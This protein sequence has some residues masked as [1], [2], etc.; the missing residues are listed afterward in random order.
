MS[1]DKQPRPP[2]GDSPEKNDESVRLHRRGFFTQGF[3]ELLRPLADMV[4]ERLARVGIPLEE[5]ACEERGPGGY[6]YGGASAAPAAEPRAAAPARRTVLR[7]PGALR[8]SEFLDRCLGSGQCVNACPVSAIRM[9]HGGDPYL[10]HKPYIEPREQACILCRD[11][12]CMQTCPSGALVPVARE[13]IRMG[14]AVVREDICLR[15]QGEDCRICAD[16]CPLGVRAIDISYEYGPVL[17]FDSGCV[18]CGV[19]EMHCPVE[20]RAIR[21]EPVDGPSGGYAPAPADE[22]EGDAPAPAAHGYQPE[23][24]QEPE[25]AMS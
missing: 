17:V 7:P 21:V 19:C 11:L 22:A 9:A 6:G 13:E 1:D 10:G 15:T 23:D 8:E 25:G 14:R 5:D 3:R 4:E 16:K 2:A 18:G 24:F 20:A 12:P